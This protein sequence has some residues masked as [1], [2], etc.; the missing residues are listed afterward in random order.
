[1]QF[2]E[3]QDSF[4][5]SDRTRPARRRG[6]PAPKVACS[7]RRRLN[8]PF[9]VSK[10]P[11]DPTVR[12]Q[13]L[14]SLRA[15]YL[16]RLLRSARL[17]GGAL[18][19]S[20]CRNS[21]PAQSWYLS[22]PYIDVNCLRFPLS[23]R[24]HGLPTHFQRARYQSNGSAAA[25]VLPVLTIPS[26]SWRLLRPL[27]H[28]LHLVILADGSVQVVDMVHHDLRHREYA[29]PLSRHREDLLTRR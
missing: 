22:F 18:I 17:S 15:S 3:S 24:C 1:M 26:R 6:I 14:R 27:L 2:C 11:R 13:P 7:R 29:Q 9:R 16:V 28:Q 12:S 20:P 21:P 10:Q 19:T 5:W 23:R 4:G 25:V 8:V